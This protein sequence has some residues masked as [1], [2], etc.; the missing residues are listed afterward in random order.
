MKHTLN[1][2]DRLVYIALTL[3]V[4]GSL[5]IVYASSFKEKVCDGVIRSSSKVYAVKEVNRSKNCLCKEVAITTK[6]SVEL[7]YMSVEEAEEVERK[8]WA[9]PSELF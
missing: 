5:S 3:A 8:C 9:L 7:G 1:H 6:E 4:T 2:I